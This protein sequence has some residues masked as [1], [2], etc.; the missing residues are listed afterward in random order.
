VRQIALEALTTEDGRDLA[1]STLIEIM[2]SDAVEASSR[3]AAAK[4]LLAY[5]YGQP[6]QFEPDDG[7]ESVDTFELIA[8]GFRRSDEEMQ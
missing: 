3:V 2:T 5:A 1:V 6:K 7:E 8:D 4:V